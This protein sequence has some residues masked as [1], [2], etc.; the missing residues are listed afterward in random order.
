M[1]SQPTNEKE[2]A[3]CH[4]GASSLNA[5]QEKPSA[6]RPDS[7]AK[8]AERSPIGSASATSGPT[9]SQQPVEPSAS[10]ASLNPEDAPAATDPAS[11]SADVQPVKRNV[12]ATVGIFYL[13]LG[14]V[15][16]YLFAWGAYMESHPIRLGG[17]LL[18]ATGLLFHAA[19]VP[20]L[21]PPGTLTETPF[22]DQ[23]SM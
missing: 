1:N 13:F 4:C 11:P 7:V 15:V 3:T 16:S 17:V 22:W 6:V 5:T 2:S 8:A 20:M 9:S 14:S 23:E 12:L 19:V 18:F 10:I 21:I